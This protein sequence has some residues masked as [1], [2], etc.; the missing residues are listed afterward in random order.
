MK[1]VIVRQFGGLDQL[2]LIDE[3]DPVPGPDQVVVR[4]TC[5]GLN[6]ADLMAR[7]GEYRTSSGDPPFTPGIEAGGVIEAVGHDVLDRRLGQRI[8]L[9]LGVRGTY[10]SH[11]LIEARRTIPAP[12][13]LPDDHLGSIWLPYLTAWGCLIWRQNLGLSQTVLLPAASSAVALAAAQIIRDFE[14]VSIGLTTSP[15]KVD[16]LRDHYDHVFCTADP[17]WPQQ[18][19]SATGGRGVSVAFDPV[20][21]GELLTQE[22]RLLAP[23]GRIWIYG[24]LGDT[25][26]VN[27]HPLIIKRAALAGWLVD[28]LLDDPAM[29]NHAYHHITRRIADG[30]YHLPIARI[31]KLHDV[32][33]AHEVMEQG[34]HIG[35]M[36]LMP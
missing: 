15:E 28:E 5:I 34:A 9:P 33:R 2:Q 11:L 4:L 7:R 31:F 6:H 13:A 19:R 29:L 17:D 36:I 22:I 25:A 35:K 12:E 8:L 30:T 18:V 23:N 21:A 10:C 32:Q 27:L 24:L 14:A 20:A 1:R 3:P 16:V 26:P